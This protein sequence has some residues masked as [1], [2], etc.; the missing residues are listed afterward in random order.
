FLE[1]LFSSNDGDLQKTANIFLKS[2]AALRVLDKWEKRIPSEMSDRVIKKATMACQ[3]EFSWLTDRASQCPHKTEAY[4][5]L[6]AANHISVLLLKD[7]NLDNLMSR[8][9]HVMPKFQ[10]LLIGI[11]G[12]KEEVKGKK[13]LH[14]W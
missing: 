4:F 11:I 10:Q 14:I 8:Y 13:K 6:I 9:A 3:K 1:T 12:K 5:L 2:G 7:F